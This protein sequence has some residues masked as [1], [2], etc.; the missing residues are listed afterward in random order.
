MLSNA[1][2]LAKFRFDTTENEPAQNLQ[3]CPKK[4]LILPLP[5]PSPHKL[6]A[7]KGGRGERVARV[8][9]RVREERRQ[10]RAVQADADARP[11]LQS[12]YPRWDRPVGRY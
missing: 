6:E 7:P 8:P 2:F 12:R 3:N 10:L 9:Q 1:Y 5:P 4:M 11:D